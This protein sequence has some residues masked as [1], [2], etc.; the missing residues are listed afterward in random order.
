MMSRIFAILIIAMLL[1]A[2][3]PASAQRDCDVAG[4]VALIRDQ[5]EDLESETLSLAILGEVETLIAHTRAACAGL[6]FEG[7]Q[8]EV[9]GPVEIL[10]GIYRAVVTTEGFVAVSVVPLTGE[11]GAGTRM[12]A[13]VF[14]QSSGE[15]SSGAEVIFTSTG[16]EALIEISNLSSPPYTLEFQLVR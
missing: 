10:A 6:V 7:A 8:E 5:L 9:I 11:C 14:N 3:L 4:V 15:A 12:S 13:L 2:A 1:F 16:C